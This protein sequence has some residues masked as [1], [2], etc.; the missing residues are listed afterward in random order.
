VVLL[1]AEAAAGRAVVDER[2]GCDGNGWTGVRPA[3]LRTKRRV[4]GWPSP[5]SARVE[6]QRYRKGGG[7]RIIGNGRRGD[8]DDGRHQTRLGAGRHSR[9]TWALPLPK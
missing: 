8:D 7:D 1:N 6:E 2:Q 5:L 9:A 4:S 3:T